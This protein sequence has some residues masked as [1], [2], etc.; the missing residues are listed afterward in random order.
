[1]DAL[2]IMT[3]NVHSCRGVDG[4][5]RPERILKV[6]RK[7]NPDVVALQELDGPAAS[8]DFAQALGMRHFY[9][10]ARSKGSTGFGN[11]LLTRFPADLVRQEALPRLSPQ[12]EP[13]A[14][15][16]LRVHTSF[17]SVEIVNTHLGLSDA[18]RVLQVDKLL[19]VDWLAEVTGAQYS[20]LCG[21]LNARPGSPAYRRLTERLRDAQTSLGQG[22]STFP[23]LFPIVRID[24][25]FT[26]DLLVARHAEV[27]VGTLA[28]LAS[29]HRPLVVDLSPVQTNQAPFARGKSSSS[30]PLERD[31]LVE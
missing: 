20:V 13:R 22:Q 26:N 18:E 25:V 15:Q 1:M 4:R 16:R 12:Q 19:S 6:I 3:Y 28:R 24:H 14:A 23:S 17:G 11:A 7:S 5:T 8:H 9:V 29:D 31:V 2:R 10:E 21:D 30:A 27:P